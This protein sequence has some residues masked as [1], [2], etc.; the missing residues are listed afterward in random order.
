MNPYAIRI[1]LRP[2]TPFESLDLALAFLRVHAGPVG[3]LAAWVLLPPAALFGLGIALTDHDLLLVIGALLL[4]PPLQAP[5]TV[6]AGRLLFAPEVPRGAVR[7]DLLGRPGLLAGLLLLSVGHATTLVCGLVLGWLPVAVL[8]RY[9]PE[10]LVLERVGLDR[11]WQRA[12]TLASDR[13]GAAFLG[14]L[15]GVAVAAWCVFAAEASLQSLV[16][17][18][19]QLGQPFGS[20]LDTP[21]RLTP[22]LVVGW[23][24]AQPVL[25]VYRLML[26]VDARTRLEGWDLQVALKQAAEDA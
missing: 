5:F 8:S 15:T 11:G 18:V 1:A 14:T 17:W 19:L 7:D 2:R 16:G 25:A 12:L 13:S 6:L 3:R 26:Y 10:V 24:G 20:L 21:P 23:L 4:G 22:Y 9:L